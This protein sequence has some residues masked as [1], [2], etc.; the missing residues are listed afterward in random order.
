MAAGATRSRP[1]ESAVMIPSATYCTC[2]K[3]GSP[4]APTFRS[5]LVRLAQRDQLDWHTA[6]SWMHHPR[7]GFF[8]PPRSRSQCCRTFEHTSQ[9]RA[10]QNIHVGP[11]E[12]GPLHARESALL[13]MMCVKSLP[14]TFTFCGRPSPHRSR[15]LARTAPQERFAHIDPSG[16]L[17]QRALYRTGQPDVP[18][19]TFPS[20]RLAARARR[21]ASAQV[22]QPV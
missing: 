14:E 2:E 4:T 11:A 8:Y 13:A 9:R 20:L 3:P 6:R 12:P 21:R 16:T 7:V 1:R 17:P 10:A 19:A 15:R 5:A 18:R 22:D